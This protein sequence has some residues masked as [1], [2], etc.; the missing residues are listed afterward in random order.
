[1]MKKRCWLLWVFVAALPLVLAFLAEAEAVELWQKCLGGSRDDK[2][3]SIQQTSD[4]GYIVVGYTNSTDG[5][6]IG[7]HGENDAWVVKLDASGDIMW[8]KC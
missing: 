2:A 8:Q 4:G 5:D 1:M 3:N 6:V 7:N